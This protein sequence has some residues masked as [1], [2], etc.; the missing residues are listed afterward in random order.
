MCLTH[1]I[2]SIIPQKTNVRPCH[3]V[4]HERGGAGA[5]RPVVR[6]ARRRGVPQ[7]APRRPRAAAVGGHQH[8]G[9]HLRRAVG[10]QVITLEAKLEISLSYF[11]FQALKIGGAF[12]TGFK[13][14]RPALRTVVRLALEVVTW[15]CGRPSAHLTPS[16]GVLSRQKGSTHGQG[17]TLV[18]VFGSP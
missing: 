12:N 10:P 5:D 1:L 11:S 2:H 8:P 16:S 7:R 9:A 3:G 13:L 17:L 18:H 14:Q 4:V 15:Q 6:R